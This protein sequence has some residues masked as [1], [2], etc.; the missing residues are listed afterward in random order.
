MMLLHLCVSKSVHLTAGSEGS[1]IVIVSIVIS[2]HLA[3]L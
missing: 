1:S 3:E 2:Y